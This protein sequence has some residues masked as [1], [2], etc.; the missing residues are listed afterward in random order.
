MT[1]ETSLDMATIGLDT[2]KID[3]HPS[4]KTAGNDGFAHE[5]TDKVEAENDVSQC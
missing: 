5:A 3:L 1:D 4:E 2:A